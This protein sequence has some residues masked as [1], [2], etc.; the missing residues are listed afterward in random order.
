MGG[1]CLEG[2]CPGGFCL[3]GG[4]VRRD[5]VLEPGNLSVDHLMLSMVYTAFGMV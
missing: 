2:F 5:F 1:F 3:G 4:F